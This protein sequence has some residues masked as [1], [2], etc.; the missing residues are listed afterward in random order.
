MTEKWSEWKKRSWTHVLPVTSLPFPQWLSGDIYHPHGG[1]LYCF[2]LVPWL[3]FLLHFSSPYQGW[4]F[5]SPVSGERALALTSHTL[6]MN[7]RLSFTE[8]IWVSGLT[9]Q[10]L[11]YLWHRDTNA[12]IAWLYLLERTY[13]NGFAWG[14]L[15]ALSSGSSSTQLKTDIYIKNKTMIPL[16]N[17]LFL[18]IFS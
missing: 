13:A 17:I 12:Y 16:K 4:F 11:V 3:H 1:S 5:C 10:G 9:S 7:P 6:S 14:S 2:W 8:G 15:N 18:L